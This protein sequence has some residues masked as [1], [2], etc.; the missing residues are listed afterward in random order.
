MHFSEKIK[1]SVDKQ[2]KKVILEI[3]VND[4]TKTVHLFDLNDFQNMVYQFD[5][6]KE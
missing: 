4:N 5:A 1:V 3:R 6:Q 2:S